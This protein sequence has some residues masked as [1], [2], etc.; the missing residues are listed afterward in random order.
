MATPLSP[1]S[2]LLETKL[3]IPAW[4]RGDVPRPR[5]SERL[6]RGVEGKLTLVS[7]PAGF[8]KTTVL[9]EWLGSTSEAASEG[10]AV[11]WVSLDEGDNQAGAFWTY[12]I[13]ALQRVAPGVG[14]N[15]LSLLQSAQAPPIE[16]VLA[17]LL[18]ELSGIPHD[19][20]VVLDDFHVIEA[21][22]VQTGVAFLLDHLPPRVHL[23]IASRA[24]PV[25]PL[26]RLRGRGELI[27]IRAA[28]LRFTLEE[29][30]AYLSEVMGLDL[31]A[32]D[33][34]TLE[35][36]TEGWIAGL[37][38]AALSMR[39]R[40]DVAGFIAGFAGGDRYIVDYLVEEV[41]Q[42]QPEEVRRFLLQTSVLDRLSGPLCDAVTGQ[43]GGRAMLE[44]LDR[45]NLFVMPLDD[46]RRWYRY[47]HLFADVLRAHL[48]EEQSAE[49]P[50]LHKRASAWYEAN[51][52]RADAIRH[53]LGAKDY[54]RAAGLVE[55][56]ARVTLRGYRS[57]RLLEW[58]RALPDDVI[59]A[60][61]VL[62]TYYAFALLGVGELDAA[63]K[64]LRDAERRLGGAVGEAEERAGGV[65]RESRMVVTAEEELRSV[66]GTI[67]LAWAFRAQVLGDTATTRDQARRALDLMPEDDHL[68]RGGAAV[69]LALAH[70]KSGDLDE[71][72]RVHD[73]GVASLERTGDISLAISAAYDGADL[74]RA[75]GR[76]SEAGRVYERAL[77]LAT[78]HGDPTIPGV[79]DLHLGLSDLHRERDDLDK[80]RWHQERGTEL[81]KRAA[82]P[83]T[84][85]RECVVGAR[86]RLVEGD[87]E[88]ALALLDRAERLEVRG[89]VPETR[90]IWALKVRMWLAQGRL[91]EAM[92]WV[93]AQKLS[94]ED[95]LDYQ[96]ELKHITL[97][98]VL[99]ARCEGEGDEEAGSDALR[100]LGRLLCEAEAHGRTGS[101]IE[102]LILQALAHRALGR[103]TVGLE[104]LGRAL[105]L[106]EPEGYVRTFVDE[107]EAMRDLLRRAVGAG[108]SSAYA[109]RL[110][111]VSEVRGQTGSVGQKDGGA[112]LIE[113]LTAREV[114]V[115]RLVAVGMR[116]QEIADQLVI[117]LPTVKR[118]IANLYGKLG[119]GHRTEAVARAQGLGL[120]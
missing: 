82:L 79:A 3:Y 52:E 73:G 26:A 111:G 47:H 96:R 72:Q 13:S 44:A 102:I 39:G 84:P 69:L 38:L 85:A 108:V 41:L 48:A 106:A 9:A 58:L 25:L 18:N 37:Q 99:T 8:G 31:A 68:W 112:G 90:P 42:R 30:A 35:G 29:A 62:C 6:E 66:P 115:M 113:P 110:L 43:D 101:V 83:Q 64:W 16:T 70:W 119:A 103:I 1:L 33:L 11:A 20:V 28:D 2:P 14:T 78:E 97:A 65:Q 98:R 93:R 74:R 51:G 10:R 95:E 117:S 23:V 60:R 27:E 109:G 104:P 75:R 46:R 114:E 15:A 89:P 120:L 50:E 61:P 107:G 40:D 17:T 105:A 63:E 4:R 21:Q 55:L 86:K 45:G 12:V 87:I 19:V 88:G 32:A 80:A 118:H 36:R 91:A 22:A 116:N 76:L 92:D 67:A 24:D 56:A 59:R 5:L 57:A 54:E 71:A 7:A 34:Q 77:Q 53:A 49:V 100:L 94:V 81:A